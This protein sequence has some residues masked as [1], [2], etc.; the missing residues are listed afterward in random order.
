MQRQ[1]R[2]MAR[3]R[4]RRLTRQ[5]L[6]TPPQ[7]RLEGRR[8]A[9]L[10]WLMGSLVAAVTLTADFLTMGAVQPPTVGPTAAAH[11]A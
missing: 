6:G 5:A 3:R 11:R 4:R 2:R 7:W 9:C 10:G 1:R 8:T